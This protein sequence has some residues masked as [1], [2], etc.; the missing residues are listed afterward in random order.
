MTGLVD[1][2][3]K[4][5]VLVD[6]LLASDTNR[7]E[8][9]QARGE[10]YLDGIMGTWAKYFFVDVY[11]FAYLIGQDSPDDDIRLAAQEVMDSL[12]QAIFASSYT[13]RVSR[14]EI[15]SYGFSVYF[16]PNDESYRSFYVDYVPEFA[17]D[18]SWVPFLLDFFMSE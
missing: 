12:D 9:A 17:G 16:P 11:K 14:L 7:S 5:D 1:A 18:T 3:E 2:V 15:G 8:I 4:L 10:A 13:E 6:E